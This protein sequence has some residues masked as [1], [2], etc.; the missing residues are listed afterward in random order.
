MKI[1]NKLIFCFLAWGSLSWAVEID[2]MQ[3]I[4]GGKDY[5]FQMS[6]GDSLGRE[7]SEFEKLVEGDTLAQGIS[8]SIP[9]EDEDKKLDLFRQRMNVEVNSYLEKDRRSEKVPLFLYKENNHYYSPAPVRQELQFDELTIHPFLLRKYQ[10]YQDYRAFW[11]ESERQGNVYFSKFQYDMPILLAKAQLSQGYNGSDLDQA[12]INIYKSQV[13]DCLDFQLGFNGS[14]GKWLSEELREK[15]KDLYGNIRYYWGDYL[16]LDY[17]YLYFDHNLPSEKLFFSQLNT[18]S[19]YDSLLDLEYVAY[20]SQQHFVVFRS[21]VFDAGYSY[22]HSEYLLDSLLALDKKYNDES[23]F[24]ALDLDFWGQN[25]AVGRKSYNNY[26]S[27]R[28]DDRLYYKGK[29]Q[30]DW[31]YGSSV[32]GYYDEVNKSFSAQKG[33]PWGFTLFADYTDKENQAVDTALFLYSDIFFQR[34]ESYKSSFCGIVFDNQI[35]SGRLAVG[36]LQQEIAEYTVQ[37]DSAIVVQTEI[38][39]NDVLQAD[40]RVRLPFSL[41]GQ[42]MALAYGVEAR[43][44][45]SGDTPYIYPEVQTLQNYEIVFY[46]DYGNVL[47]LGWRNHNATD[48]F[49]SFSDQSKLE[50]VSSDKMLDYYL[51]LDLTNKFSVLMDIKN[52]DKDEDYLGTKIYRRHFKI[53]FIWYLFD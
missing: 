37:A 11:S 6:T 1:W 8:D 49:A 15:T 48:Y 9:L 38:Y 2:T 39:D 27:T 23:Y 14:S 10:L 18:T 52:Y 32:R 28:I 33:L 47:T 43:K 44:F 51:Q 24:Y 17:S 21:V 16:S 40:M 53:N 19:V 42:K 5:L 25:L 22:S 35:F 30:A 3:G 29:L 41:W 4:S 12:I 36:T 20:T 31:W 50:A 34:V 7:R 13:Y 46:F 26:E 45:L